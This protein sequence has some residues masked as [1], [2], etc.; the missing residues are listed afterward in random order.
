MAYATFTHSYNGTNR[1]FELWVN[2]KAD[3]VDVENNTSSVE[4]SSTIS[5][6]GGTYFDSGCKITINGTVVYNETKYWS[7]GSYPAKDGTIS[8]VLNN[9]PHNADGTKTISFKIEGYSNQYSWKSSGEQ[10]LELTAV[11]RASTPSTNVSEITL[12]AATKSV[13]IN[14]NRASSSFTHTIRIKDGS[15]I[16]ETLATKTS[17][18]SIT[19]SVSRDTYSR[20]MSN[21]MNKNFTVECITYNGDTELGTKTCTIKM[22]IPSTT[23]PTIS[24]SEE[25][26]VTLPVSGFW[27]QGKSKIKLKVTGTP[28]LNS[29]IASYQ[30]V[31]EGITYNNDKFISTGT[32]NQKYVISDTL[33]GSGNITISATVTDERGKTATKSYNLTR[34]PYSNPYIDGSCNRCNANEVIMDSGTYLYYNITGGITSL[35]SGSTEY[36]RMTVKIRWKLKTDDK[37]PSANVKTLSNNVTTTTFSLSG[38]LSTNDSNVAVTFDPNLS[39]DIKFEVSDKFTTNDPIPLIRQLTTGFDLMNFNVNGKSMAI[40]KMSEAG[41]NDTKLEIAMATYFSSQP[42]VNGVSLATA[43]LSIIYPIGALYITTKN[44]NPATTLG[45]GT[46]TRVKDRMLLGYGDTYKTIKATGG[47][48]ALQAHTHGIPELSG[49]TTSTGAHGHRITDSTTSYGSGSQSAWRCLAWS[50]TNHDW[51]QDIYTPS[52]GGGHN[53]DISTT[54]STTNSTGSGAASS[55]VEGNMPPYYV[56]YIWERTA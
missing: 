47:N 19:W 18:A 12:D 52:D 17:N 26:G 31:I 55:S 39:Y 29:P 5:G 21:V 46:W 4:W 8:G 27:I 6:G 25:Q 22:N 54:A 50:G 13:T 20:I 3:S 38:R 10:Y 15:N 14:T 24:T 23:V 7:A 34:T 36:N 16:I 45:F 56:V 40:G 33:S 35:K 9:I 30:A 49:S 44:E 28:A 42:Y 43:I 1:K 37:Y 32:A 41:T 11:P 53:H 48:R 51:W 2:N